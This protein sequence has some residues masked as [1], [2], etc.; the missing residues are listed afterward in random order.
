MRLQRAA[1]DALRAG[2]A[3]A[4]LWCAGFDAVA[5]TGEL[6]AGGLASP[7]DV[8][9]AGDGSGRMFV[10]EQRGS[11]R[12]LKAGTLAPAPFLDLGARVLSGGEQGLLG[13]AFHSRYAANGRF[14]VDYTRQPD[15]ATVIAEYRRGAADADRADPGSERILLTIPQPFSNHN[16]GALRFGPD[17][18]LYIGTGDG[19]AANDPGNRAQDT[20]ELL[21]KILRIDVDGAM[22]YAIP[23]G[24]P[25]AGGGGR[26]EI[27]ALGLRNP[28]RIAFDRLTG[29]LFI[30]DVGQNALEEIDWLAAGTGAGANFGWRVMEASTC[31][32]LGGGVPCFDAALT[33][34]ILQYGHD[35][36][37]SVTGGMVY[38]GIGVPALAGRYVYGDYCSGRIWSAGRDASGMWTARELASA[39][40]SISAFGEDEDGE[41]YFADYAHGE[42]R[43][44]V[45]EATDR[46][47]VIEYYHAG[48]DHYFITA[49]PAEMLALDNGVLRGWSRTGHAFPARAAPGAGLWELCRFYLPPGQGDSHFFSASPAECDE[50]AA[51]CPA[52]VRE[53]PTGTHVALPDA[54]GGACP[55]G[56]LPVYRIWNQR[57]DS[58]HRYTT[59]IAIRDQMVARG[60]AAE[61]YGPEAVAM[62][63]LP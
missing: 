15:G 24:N 32:N 29:D 43:R 36:G 1:R 7:V 33:R 46:V 55:S 47:D 34:P 48:L 26:A 59:S 3:I 62:C 54:A 2:A 39:G 25:F 8:V 11:I 52:F 12:I 58:N 5:V 42:L 51:R 44:L 27:W 31:T 41:L 60:G 16:G 17:G 19:G 6:V 50:V 18:F 37:C 10:V 61:G 56:A 30:G 49:T 23:A 20:R 9:N 40:G 13:A 21:G 28:W 57:T 35:L 45:G 4:A 22:P 63:A 14:F 53:G 38:R